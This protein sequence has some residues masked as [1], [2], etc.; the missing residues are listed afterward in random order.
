[1]P[2]NWNPPIEGMPEESVSRDPHAADIPDYPGINP[3]N[4]VG[5]IL[6]VPLVSMTSVNGIDSGRVRLYAHDTWL[7]VH[8]RSKLT[9]QEWPCFRILMIRSRCRC[10]FK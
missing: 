5:W 2:R 10:Q 7:S 8:G 4:Q 1:M 3:K 6:L 9:C